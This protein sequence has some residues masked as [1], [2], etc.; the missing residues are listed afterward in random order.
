MPDPRDRF[1]A[2]GSPAH[3]EA[4]L[5]LIAQLAE[6]QRKGHESTSESDIRRIDAGEGRFIL[7]GP[8]GSGKTTFLNY[9][10]SSYSDRLEEAGVCWVRL[11]LSKPFRKGRLKSRIAYQSAWIMLR[12]YL[13]DPARSRVNIAGLVRFLGNDWK[14]Y[15][16]RLR[17]LESIS[18][19]L[20]DEDAERDDNEDV[21]NIPFTYADYQLLRRYFEHEGYRF[22][23]VI[24]GLDAIEPIHEHTELLKTWIEDVVSLFPSLGKGAS[25]ALVMTLQKF[26][27]LNTP[28]TSS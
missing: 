13:E 23:F 4:L 7:I 5:T 3:L 12:K 24:D 11:N 9:V 18:D 21:F 16:R 10:V 27:R 20:L 19:A 2:N 15:I 25:A 8:R 14:D 22:F 28:A 26:K 6:A 17:S 1:P